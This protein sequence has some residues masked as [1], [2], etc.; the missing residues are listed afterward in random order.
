[1][2]TPVLAA[3]PR[4]APIWGL[5]HRSDVYWRKRERCSRL[6]GARIHSRCRAAVP[7]VTS[8]PGVGGGW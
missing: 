1:M 4:P 7:I 8:Q 6:T 3:E 5:Q 2:V